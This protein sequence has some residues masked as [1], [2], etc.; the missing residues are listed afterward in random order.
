MKNGNPAKSD[1][2]SFGNP[3]EMDSPENVMKGWVMRKQS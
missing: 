2:V 3:I 1:A